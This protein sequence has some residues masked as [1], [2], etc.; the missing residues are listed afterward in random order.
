M[1]LPR[2]E[3]KSGTI[4]TRIRIMRC[5]VFSRSDQFCGSNGESV[6]CGQ[7]IFVPSFVN[8]SWDTISSPSSIRASLVPGKHRWIFWFQ[9]TNKHVLWINDQPTSILLMIRI[10]VYDVFFVKVWTWLVRKRHDETQ[11]REGH[12]RSV[13]DYRVCTKTIKE[14]NFGPTH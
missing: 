2:P 7:R 3:S 4:E 11:R 1:T 10:D 6:G 9:G 13:R 5:K 14:S 12:S 8:F